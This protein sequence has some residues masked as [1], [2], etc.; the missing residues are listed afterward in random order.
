MKNKMKIDWL[1]L[2]IF[3]STIF[4]SATNPFIHK[5]LIENVTNSIIAAEQIFSCLSIII[6]GFVWNKFADKL[7]K[8][9]PLYCIVEIVAMIA[10]VIVVI[11][12][13]N[14]LL[15]YILR[16]IECALIY[17]N[18]ICGDIKLIS[19]RYNQEERQKFDNNKKS[20]TALA[21]ILGSTI[22]IIL[23][24]DFNI[25]L[26]ISVLGNAIYNILCIV[27]YYKTI[28]SK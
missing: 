4:N 24:L 28:R 14:L 11:I 12:S 17:R 25:M 20:V 6:S 16:I 7:F 21:T 9:Y 5:L 8:H 10:I 1:L 15:C 22:A 23:N 2:T 18:I 26:C 19:I 3:L 27:I 13:E